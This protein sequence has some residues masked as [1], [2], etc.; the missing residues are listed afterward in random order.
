MHVCT[1]EFVYMVSIYVC[2]NLCLHVFQVAASGQD[3]QIDAIDAQLRN[4]SSSGLRTL[5]MGYRILEEAEYNAFH[6]AFVQAQQLIGGDGGDQ[7]EAVRE[8][9]CSIEV[10][11]VIVGCTG[12]EDK[13]QDEVE[14][15]S[16]H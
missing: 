5:V 8:A 2:M 1:Y 10:N 7:D 4:F 16:Y 6:R 14:D 9:V 12:I 13:L 11:L 3:Q 15:V